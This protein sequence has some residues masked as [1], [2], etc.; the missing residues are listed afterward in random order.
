[1]PTLNDPRRAVGREDDVRVNAQLLR[2]TVSPSRAIGVTCQ[3]ENL[4]R[5][6]IVVA[7]H[8]SR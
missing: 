7:A 6:W 2:D 8:S 1:M 3:I 4:T 5:G